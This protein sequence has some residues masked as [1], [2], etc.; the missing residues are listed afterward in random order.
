[1]PFLYEQLLEVTGNPVLLALLVLLG[2]YVLEDAAIV[3]A[4]LLS[5]DGL[6]PSGLAFLALFIGIFTGDL[7]L[8]FL[9]RYLNRI[10]YL[11]S[12]LDL[13]IFLKARL[14]FDRKMITTVLLVRVI[15][16]LRLPVYT[17]YGFF[18]LSFSFFSIL[19]LIASLIWTTAV[20][21]FF[22]AIGSMFWSELGYWKWALL[23]VIIGLI[24]F[25]HK[26]IKVAEGFLN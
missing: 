1:M 16:G 6:L 14:W 13:K 4:A 2:T 20:F 8:Y 11:K 21:Y 19:V 5:A 18:N 23:P 24:V 22:V 7:G 26:K 25:G 9:G 10:P 17:A 3:T 15:P 12:W